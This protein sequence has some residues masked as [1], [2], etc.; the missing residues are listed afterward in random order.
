MTFPL[1]SVLIPTYEYARFLP[2]AIESVLQQDFEDFELIIADD[3]STDDTA[4]VCK[5][6]AQRDS[7]ICFVRHEKNLGMV[8]NWNWCLRK[9]RGKYI[10][11]LLADDRLNHP[12]ALRRMVGILEKHPEV[13]LITSCRL[14]INEQSAPV[15]L[16]NGLGRKEKIFSK[17]RILRRC[18]SLEGHSNLIGEPSA[19]LFRRDQALRG[20]HG[21]YRQLVDFEMWLHL[22]QYGDLYYIGEPLCCF[23]RHPQQ[24]TEI[25][26]RR[27]ICLLESLSLFATYGGGEDKQVLFQQ[28]HI[29]TK[30]GA[31]QLP[32][33]AQMKAHFTPI[34]YAGEYL[35]YRFWRPFF[36]LRRSLR[37][38]ILARSV[39]LGEAIWDLQGC[40]QGVLGE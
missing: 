31:G 9:A 33:V 23:R 7:R 6:Y 29:I 36:N 8:E 15:C 34:Q 17:E 20:F 5:V 40:S 30:K 39:S 18:F 37:T 32:E 26:R 38:R 2:E 10:K 21:D 28:L 27:G 25:N 19:A 16:K 35:R 3:A 14:I 24:Q 1:V 4:E 22:L 13:S 11:F 12:L